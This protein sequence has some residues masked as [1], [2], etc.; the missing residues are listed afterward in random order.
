MLLLGFAVKVA[1]A[2][3][4]MQVTRLDDYVKWTL[5]GVKPDTA[6]PPLKSLQI[7]PEDCL[8]NVSGSQ[9]LGSQCGNED[10]I[11]MTMYYY[12]SDYSNKDGGFS[13][14]WPYVFPTAPLLCNGAKT[15]PCVLGRR[16]AGAATA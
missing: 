2:P 16:D 5:Y 4:Q 6:K 12:G 8:P 1:Y 15:R 13:G 10:E 3:N 9:P 11:R 14:H 7:R